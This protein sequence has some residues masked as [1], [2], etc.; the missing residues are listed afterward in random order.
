MCLFLYLENG[1]RVDETNIFFENSE[2]RHQATIGRRYHIVISR[3][4]HESID[5]GPHVFEWLPKF[6]RI[7]HK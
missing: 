3:K 4:F 1:A 6:Y 2:G 5:G 7:K